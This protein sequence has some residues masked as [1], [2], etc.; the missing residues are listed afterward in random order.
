MLVVANDAVVRA[1]LQQVLT[2]RLVDLGPTDQ[3]ALRDCPLLLRRIVT[4]VIIFFPKSH[5]YSCP[6]TL[7]DS[8]FPRLLPLASSAQ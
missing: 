2:D 1:H 3:H 6:R 5:G 8:E 4:S 7:C